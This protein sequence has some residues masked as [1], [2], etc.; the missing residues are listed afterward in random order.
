MDFQT[1][2]IA[3]ARLLNRHK[4]R[5]AYGG[6]TLLFFLEIPVKPRDLDVV[7]HIMDVERAKTLLI[8]AGAVLM[9]EKIGSDQF[10]TKKFYTFLWNDMEIDF[11]A[12]PGIQTNSRIYFMNFDEKGPWKKTITENEDIYLCDPEDWIEYYGLMDNRQLRVD[13]LKQYVE[14][15]K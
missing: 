5:W 1:T 15:R 4:I 3:L 14:N 11:M 8:E 13:Q 7:V 2:S 6:S 10:L 9:E 12:S